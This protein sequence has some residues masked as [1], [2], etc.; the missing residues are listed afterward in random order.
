MHKFIGAWGLCTGKLCHNNV[1]SLPSA[2][3]GLSLQLCNFPGLVRVVNLKVY[4]QLVTWSI[5]HTVKSSQST[6]HTYKYFRKSTHHTVSSS[7]GQLATV[8]SIFH[9][10]LRTVVQLFRYI[11]ENSRKTVFFAILCESSC[12]CLWWTT[13]GDGSGGWRWLMMT[14]S[15]SAG[16]RQ[17]RRMT[18]T[19]ADDDRQQMMWNS[20]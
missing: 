1:I 10:T 17:W 13:D 6:S 12:K 15:N 5:R 11:S 16:E 4:S 2:P 20:H 7:H 14:V 18:S 19:A 8:K 9:E 3:V